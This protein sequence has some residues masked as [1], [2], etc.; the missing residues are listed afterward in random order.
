MSK[1]TDI[2]KQYWGYDNFRAL[3][4][5]IVE[6]VGEGKD[7]LGLMPT[8]GG[9]SITF[10][11]PAMAR[12][13]LCLVV[14]PLIALMKDQVQNLKKKGIKAAAIYTGMTSQEISVTYD[15]CIFGGYKFLYLSPERIGTKTFLDK[16]PN[17][18]VSMIAIDES[19]CI[20]QWG[21][22]FRPSYL[23]IAEIRKL[24]PDVPVLAVTA[25]ATPEV[26]KDI[27]DKLAFPKYNVFQKSFERSNLVYAVRYVEDK[28]RFLLKM[29]S[30]VPGTAIVY[31][32]SRKRTKEIS[33]FLISEGFTADFYHA[34]L[35]SH[36]KDAKQ[37]AWTD[38]VT[39]VIVATNAFGMGI[40]KPDVRLVVHVDL[41][42]SLEAYFQEAGRAGRDGEKAYAVLLYSNSDGTKIKKRLT[43]NFPP[44]ETVK[45]VYD[46]IH[47]YLQIAVGTGQ[48]RT[49]EFD[50]P[51]FCKSFKLPILPTYSAIQIL[52]RAGYLQWRDERD[53]SSRLMYYDRYALLEFASSGVA[54]KVVKATLRHYTGLFTDVAYI[55]EKVIAKLAN[56]TEKQ[57][58]DVLVAMSSVKLGSYVPR[59]NK[60]LITLLHNRYDIK[61]V[62]ITREAYEDMH[63]RFQERAKSVLE[64]ATM[65]HRCRSQILLGY[66]G[67]DAKK[68]GQCDVC[69]ARNKA[70]LSDEE[71]ENL[72]DVII[73]KLR[74]KPL[75]I[76]L[77]IDKLPYDEEKLVNALRTLLDDGVVEYDDLQQLQLLK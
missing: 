21:Y 61:S 43:D 65:R 66:F 77:L 74:A 71:F 55:D 18:N 68:C 7:T 59:N 39:R 2:L 58:Y 3:Q 70:S 57:V 76:E 64:Y 63:V 28:S 62:H 50:F 1:Y 6:S 47:D 19:H 75:R 48:D 46:K 10:Q 23:R 9:K 17:L 29:L 49:V 35:T 73:D 60:P 51:D 8:G 24:L 54:E 33:D 20:S 36:E 26:A 32:R 53:N 25:T 16:L 5:D 40:D 44:K 41:P 56:S 30:S 15:N 42:D 45:N 22:D 11:V 13:G 27:Q 69:L 12:D 14:T 67:E 37:K 38:G 34:G 31:A 4:E 52:D 72:S